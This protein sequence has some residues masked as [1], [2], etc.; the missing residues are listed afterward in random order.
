[1]GSLAVIKSTAADMD[2]RTPQQAGL[3]SF[4]QS[5]ENDPAYSSVLSVLGTSVLIYI[6]TGL[7]H[8]PTNRV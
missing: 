4:W 7:I 8:I 5:P 1:M 6:A 2:E 3:D